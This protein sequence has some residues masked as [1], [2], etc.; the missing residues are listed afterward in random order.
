VKCMSSLQRCGKTG[1]QALYKKWHPEVNKFKAA[2]LMEIAESTHP[3]DAAAAVANHLRDQ[4][5]QA[6]IHRPWDHGNEYDF[7]W[8]SKEA[9]WKSFMLSNRMTYERWTLLFRY[10]CL[11]G[12]HGVDVQRRMAE[13][14]AAEDKDRRPSYEARNQRPQLGRGALAGIKYLRGNDKTPPTST[15]EGSSASAAASNVTASPASQSSPLNGMTG[16]LQNGEATVDA[17]PSIGCAPAAAT[18]IANVSLTEGTRDLRQMSSGGSGTQRAEAAVQFPPLPPGFAW[19]AQPSP[20]SRVSTTTVSELTPAQPSGPQ[21]AATGSASSPSSA[22]RIAAFVIPS[23]PIEEEQPGQADLEQMVRLWRSNKRGGG[24]HPLSPQQ[25]Q[26][27]HQ[28]ELRCLR[29]AEGQRLAEQRDSDRMAMEAVTAVGAQL[30]VLGSLGHQYHRYV[31]PYVQSAAQPTQQTRMAFAASPL[32][33]RSVPSCQALPSVRASAVGG[34]GFNGMP[35]TAAVAGARRGVA[36]RAATAVR[37]GGVNG[38]FGRVVV[39]SGDDDDEPVADSHAYR[40]GSARRARAGDASP[41]PFVA[42]MLQHGLLEGITE[43]SKA[44]EMQWQYFMYMW[45]NALNKEEMEQQA[46]AYFQSMVRKREQQ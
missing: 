5:Q 30:P 21:Q 1:I 19:V 26:Q 17:H 7:N 3:E 15:V 43:Y 8:F 38:M 20:L 34:S 14:S 36:R 33:R 37:V 28:S 24:D 46:W 12:E 4:M 35:V 31:Q 25:Q 13:D 2:T 11:Q 22:A 23:F 32:S 6:N 29:D 39:G 40:V 10:H 18:S 44:E 27:L 16:E 41:P 9:S 42:D 45:P